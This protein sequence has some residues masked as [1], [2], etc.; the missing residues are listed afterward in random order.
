MISG[1]GSGTG[2][3]YGGAVACCGIFAAGRNLAA[4]LECVE[5]SR[6]L[7]ALA[8]TCRIGGAL[9]VAVPLGWV[10]LEIPWAAISSTIAR[11]HHI[12]VPCY[13]AA[14]HRTDTNAT[15]NRWAR[16]CRALPTL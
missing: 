12:P 10:W 4:V 15:T 1:P 2:F 7:V 8:V 9:Q 13:Q 5:G 6:D 16:S 11:R 14:L 3:E